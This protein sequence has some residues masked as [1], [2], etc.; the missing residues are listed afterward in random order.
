MISI[1]TASYNYANYIKECIDSVLSQDFTDWEL[2]IVDDGSVDNSVEIIKSYTD[3]R[4]RL[5]RNEKNSG[6]K[7]TL[8]R[9]I[10]EAGGEYIAFLESDDIWRT[11]YL[12]KKN[13]I[14]QKYPDAALIFNDVELFGDADKIFRVKKIFEKNN[15]FLSKFTYPKNLFKYLNVQNRILTFSAVMIKKSVLTEEVFN[16]PVDKLL[17]WW[18]YIHLAKEN[19]FY[20]IPEKLTK[21]RIHQKSYISAKKRRPCLINIAAYLD[22]YNKNKK[23]TAL[24]IF[25]IKTLVLSGIYFIQKQFRKVQFGLKKISQRRVE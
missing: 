22:I 20:Y 3:S 9:G 15:D 10:Q 24:L 17:D 8:L 11:D 6:L 2:I 12:S 7:Q 14:I 18:L 16:T 19:Y 4:I 5:I 13:D 21:W 1:I 23:D 25:I